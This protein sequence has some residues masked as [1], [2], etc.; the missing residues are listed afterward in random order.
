MSEKPSKFIAPQRNGLGA[1]TVVLP[2]GP[3]Q[4]LL[5]ALCGHFAAIPETS[6]QQRFADGLVLGEQ[7]QALSANQP[8]KR[9]MVVHYYRQ[10][11]AETPIPFQAKVLYADA[12][13]VVADKPHFLPVMPA[14]NYVQHTL[15]TRLSQ[16]L[17]NPHLVPL[18]RID[19]TT[20][21]LVLFSAQPSSRAAYQGL[22]RTQ[23]ISKTYQAL[24]PALPQLPMPYRHCSRMVE[25]EPFFRMQEAPGTPNSET[26]IEVL[27]ANGPHW[28]YQLSPV[29]GKK[30]QLRVHMAALGAPIVG[31]DFYPTLAERAEDDF[32]QPL[33]LLAYGL[34]FSDP[35][36][37]VARRFSSEIL[38]G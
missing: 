34:A 20:A 24:A 16:Q 3:W 1:S 26:L 18:H 7:G 5:Q 33:K 35:L 27:A 17:D 38:L 11:A 8:F 30:H 2:P 9:G 13:L 6:W 21:G 37:G 23:Q 32:S 25:G 31:D 28:R 14:G 12:H 19:R 4:T 36:T 15:L 10:L 29:T 22:F